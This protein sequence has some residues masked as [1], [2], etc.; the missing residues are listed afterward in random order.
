M[1]LVI[2]KVAIQ[3]ATNLLVAEPFGKFLD[4][5]VPAELLGAVVAESASSDRIHGYHYTLILT[6]VKRF[7]KLNFQRSQ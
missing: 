3:H 6:K 4:A 1:E 7:R 2:I 5:T